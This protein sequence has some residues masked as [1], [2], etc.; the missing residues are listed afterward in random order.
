[1]IF[2]QFTIRQSKRL[3]LARMCSQNV[4]CCRFEFLRRVFYFGGIGTGTYDLFV[5]VGHNIT[6]QASFQCRA[7][8][9]ISGFKKPEIE[10]RIWN[11]VASEKSF[12]DPK[13]QKDADSDL[14]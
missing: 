12:Y 3:N 8:F 11:A 9:S 7:A 2:A 13:Y 14:S 4:T 10:K 1:L 5:I 6:F